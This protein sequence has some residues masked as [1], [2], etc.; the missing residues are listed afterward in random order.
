MKHLGTQYLETDRLILR[1]FVM[2]DANAMFANWASDP[3]VTK[4]LMW[5]THS[6]PAVSEHVL[7]EWVANYSQENYYQ[8]AIVLKENGADPIG[9]IS[10]VHLDDQTRM[11][12]VGYCIG[13]KWWHQGIT[14]E[15]M[16]CVIDF[17]FDRVGMQRVE[18]RHDPRNPHSG[19]VMK[20]CG[21][22]YEGTL[23]QSDWNNQGICDACYYA[24][25]ASD[26]GC[27]NSSLY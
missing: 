1:R 8:W 11:A 2:A 7:R 18:S 17:L 3:E 20:K 14:S 6:S 4:Y 26:R 27:K 22:A 15:A 23:R 5:P 12:H 13:R 25:L 19:G 24:I 10:V 9:D 16:Q 21:M